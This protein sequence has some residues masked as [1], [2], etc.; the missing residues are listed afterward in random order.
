[1]SKEQLLHIFDDSSCLN[2]RQMK[3]Y[4]NGIMTNEESHAVEVH[5][6]SCPFCNEAIEGLFEQKEGYAV[7]NLVALDGDFLKDHLSLHNPQIHLNS[8]TAAQAMPQQQPYRRR[9]KAKSK[10]QPFWRNVSIA[11]ILLLTFGSLWYYRAGHVQNTNPV[12]AQRTEDEPKVTPP[13]EPKDQQTLAALAPATQP[14]PVTEP[15]GTLP[16]QSVNNSLAAPRTSASEDV[17]AIKTTPA[18]PTAKVAAAEHKQAEQKRGSSRELEEVVVTQYKVPLIDKNEALSNSMTSDEIEKMPTRTTEG[19]AATAPG[20]Y[21]GNKNLNIGG[22]RADGTQ[23]IVDGVQVRSKEAKVNNIDKAAELYEQ[24]K[25]SAA[26]KLYDKEMSGSNRS[27]RQKAAV[28]AARCYINIG[29]KQKAISLLQSIV[30]EGG[31]QKKAAKK[32]LKDLEEGE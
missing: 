29:N 8:L 10:T 13:E 4:V 20:V 32:L 22:A 7:E 19:V 14:E 30:D 6:N 5:L 16:Q 2:R 9:R 21:Q 31:P 17:G 25:Y 24:K 3:D 28:M 18:M 12:I 11:A 26:L 23:Y 15:V 1:M 27:D